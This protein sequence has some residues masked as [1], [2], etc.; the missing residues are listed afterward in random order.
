MD[1]MFKVSVIAKLCK[2]DELR[3]A[4]YAI[5]V[6]GITVTPA[7]SYGEHTI[8]ESIYRGV[9]EISHEEPKVLVEIVVCEISPDV[10]VKTALEVLQTGALDDGKITVEPIDRVVRVRTGE[11]N[12]AALTN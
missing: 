3:D 2:F 4:L 8:H 10:V 5:G 6:L 1:S 9:K 12:A 7:E 11:E